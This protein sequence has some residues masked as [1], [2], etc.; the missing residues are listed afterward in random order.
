MSKKV[1]GDLNQKQSEILEFIKQEVAKKNYPPS[2]REICK[3]VGLRST[4]SVHANLTALEEKGYIRRDP[5]KPR[6][7]T[8][9]PEQLPSPLADLN[10]VP[11]VGEVTAGMPILARENIEDYFPLP[12]S[13]KGKTFMLR[14]KGDSMSGA[15]IMDGDL[16]VVR[17]QN[18]ADNG[19]IVVAMIG[20]EATIKR[21]YREKDSVR[22]QP[23]ND[24]YAPIY[25]REVDIVGKV[26]GLF[27][28]L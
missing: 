3:A 17:C 28:Y 7:I 18:W 25:S 24:N 6:A 14:V 2:V 26:T 12:S 20:D 19:D 27:R 5:T 22:L 9:P 4:S 10:L 13:F 16:V 1:S 15:G 21:F 11:V 23:E 8:L